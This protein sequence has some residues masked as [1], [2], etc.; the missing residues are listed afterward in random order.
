MINNYCRNSLSQYQRVFDELTI[1]NNIII[2]DNKIVMPPS[3]YADVIEL[4]NEDHSGY[5]K[6]LK[7]CVGYFLS[8]F[9]SS[10]NDSPSKNMKNVFYFV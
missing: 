7:A 6:T 8:F 1:V 9:Y 4:A 10:P 5:E 2:R 3:L